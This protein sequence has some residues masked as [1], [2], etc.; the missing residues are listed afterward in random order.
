MTKHLNNYSVISVA[1]TEYFGV[2]ENTTDQVVWQAKKEKDA[3]RKARLFD[4]GSGF[5][6]W[7]P[8]FIL[9]R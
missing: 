9:K 2:Y 4:N 1:N 5:S 8:A 3:L 6:G 7:T